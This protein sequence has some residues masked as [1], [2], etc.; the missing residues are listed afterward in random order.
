M[1]VLVMRGDSHETIRCSP[2]TR[3]LRALEDRRCASLATPCQMRTVLS[4]QARPGSGSGV[5]GLTKRLP[6]RLG[7]LVTSRQPFDRVLP[8][9]AVLGQRSPTTRAGR[10]CA[11]GTPASW[12]TAHRAA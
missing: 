7:H 3:E 12:V 4:W 9:I 1:H 11:T 6:R 5:V 2:A 8:L 10:T